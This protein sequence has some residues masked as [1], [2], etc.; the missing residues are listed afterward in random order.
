MLKVS[1]QYLSVD[2]S[3]VPSGLTLAGPATQKFFCHP[4][5]AGLSLGGC[6]LGTIPA[7]GM[8]GSPHQLCLYSVLLTTQPHQ[9][10]PHETLPDCITR[11]FSS[12]LGPARRTQ[13]AT[14]AKVPSFVTQVVQ[15]TSNARF[16]RSHHSQWAICPSGHVALCI[17]QELV[18]PL[19]LLP[20]LS[21]EN[22]L[23][24]E[25]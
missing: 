4:V 1:H 2:G 3:P 12:R 20:M 9:S 19:R 22:P 7:P 8:G 5:S 13:P 6:A 11:A 18:L 24:T 23:N 15:I 14:K 10:S 16:P 25:D 17:R 21:C